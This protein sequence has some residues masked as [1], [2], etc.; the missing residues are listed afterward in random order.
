MRGQQQPNPAHPSASV[1]CPTIAL[2]PFA[3]MTC[4]KHSRFT[5]AGLIPADTETGLG[6]GRRLLNIRRALQD[7][8]SAQH[9]AGLRSAATPGHSPLYT[10]PSTRI[11]CPVT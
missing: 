5:G 7:K 11:V 2:L 8:L 4:A 9:Q 6:V 1:S 3:F 10:P